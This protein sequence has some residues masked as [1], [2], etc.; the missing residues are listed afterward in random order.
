MALTGDAIITRPLSAQKDAGF[1]KLIELIRAQ[2]AAFTNLEISL[3]DYETYP[4]VESGGI[5]LRAAPAMAKEL[6]W[7]GFGIASFANNHAMDWGVE[8]MRLTQRHARDAGLVIAGVGESLREARA[9]RFLDTA[10]GRVALIAA[11][12]TFKTEARAGDSLGDMPTRPGL[13]P[14]RFSTVN[15]MTPAGWLALQTMAT[16]LGKTLP[17][18]DRV[19]FM[20]QTFV[21]GE[22]AGQQ[23]APHPQDLEQI[24][25]AVRSG[26]SLS[27]LTIVSI[28]AHQGG[29][30]QDV[31]AQFL[32]T[33][34]RAMIDAGADS[35]V[36][37]GPHR[38]RGIEIYKG[39]PIFYSLGDF[40]FENETVERLPLDDYEARGAD[41][42]KGVAGLN[43]VRYDNDRRGFPTRREV[44]ESVIAV[45]RWRNRTLDSIELY[46]ISLGFGK[47]RALR[48]RPALADE[49][50]G[51]KI[52]EDLRQLSAPFGTRIEY[53]DGIGVVVLD[54]ASNPGR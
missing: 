42:A 48:G 16:E 10:K 27:G 51:H 31:P 34:A 3:H 46:P 41:P 43:D 44:W 25:A 12:S 7:A 28:H 35:V 14:L 21:L 23:T 36:G 32:S 47:P 19:T 39:R 30:T 22:R 1:L 9:A 2:D 6:V 11:A 8:G 53:R 40:L 5:H 38:L 20:G 4:R 45:P 29:A 54:S 17:Q 18:A 50:L 26:H 37:H 49:A 33:F 13:S 15:M 24:A 52:I